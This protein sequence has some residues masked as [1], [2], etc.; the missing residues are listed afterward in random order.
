M[1]P[2]RL[3]GETLAV[4]IK[5][6]NNAQFEKICKEFVM[7]YLP[8]NYLQKPYRKAGLDFDFKIS[9][10]EF[11]V[12]L[13]EGAEDFLD[14]GYEIYNLKLSKK[15]A[16]SKLVRIKVDSHQQGQW[17]KLQLQLQG[18]KTN[19]NLKNLDLARGFIQ[20]ERGQLLKIHP[21]DL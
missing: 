5:V 11:D 2:S 1:N 15:H 3:R 10:E 13:L 8:F 17:L 12:W 7:S 20:D 14:R 9:R 4:D 6:K 21:E 18:E 16:K 19:Q